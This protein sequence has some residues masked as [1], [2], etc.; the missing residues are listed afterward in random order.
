MKPGESKVIKNRCRYFEIE[1][2]VNLLENVGG[3]GLVVFAE[4]AVNE[5]YVK[6]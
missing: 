6:H 3:I 1:I 2:Y 4:W 5:K